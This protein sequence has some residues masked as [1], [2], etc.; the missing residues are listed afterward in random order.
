MNAD[1]N[2]PTNK[3]NTENDNI[4]DETFASHTPDWLRS[5]KGCE[6]CS[7]KEAHEILDSLNTVAYVFL[8][9][10]E[11]INTKAK[12]IQLFKPDNKKA[13]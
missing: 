6:H 9:A 10:A 5:F 1:N 4:S 7:D 3:T 13:A 8:Y 12:T 2:N 11:N